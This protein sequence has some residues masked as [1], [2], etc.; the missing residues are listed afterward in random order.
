[1]IIEIEQDEVK[2]SS[3]PPSIPTPAASLPTGGRTPDGPDPDW[4]ALFAAARWRF[5]PDGAHQHEE[6]DDDDHDR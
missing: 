6:R 4:D 3:A 1:M 2:P 5:N